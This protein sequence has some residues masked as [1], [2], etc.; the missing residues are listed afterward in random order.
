[1]SRLA[2]FAEWCH[3]AVTNMGEGIQRGYVLP[4]ALTEKTIPQMTAMTKMPV[5]EHL[6]YAPIKQMP[7]SFPEPERVRLARL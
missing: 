5:E 1:M 7:A 3:T 2:A 6:Y 4:K